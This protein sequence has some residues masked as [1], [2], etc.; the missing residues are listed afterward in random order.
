MRRREFITLLSGA[1]VAWPLAALAQQVGKLPTIGLLGVA[2]A[3]AWSRSMSAFLK[4]LQ[5]LGWAEGRTVAIEY[6]WAE[7]RRERF[8]EIAAEFVRLKVDVIVTAGGAVIA[9]KQETSTIPI[10][11]AVASDPVGSGLV[12]SLARPGGNVTGLSVQAGDLVG[13]RVRAI[14]RDGPRST[15]LGVMANVEYPAA[16]HELSEVKATADAMGLGIAV[17]EIRRADEIAAAIETIKGRAEALYVAIDALTDANRDRIA[18]LALAARLPM[19]PGFQEAIDAGG[20]VFY[21]PNV[22][23]LF[24]QAAGLVDRILRGIKPA[25]VPVEQ[26]TKIDLVINL[27]VARTLGLVVP[28]SLLARADEVIE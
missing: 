28:P 18:A 13:K 7:G 24:R 26:P 12:A 25:D 19:S 17:L 2:T 15:T 3:S 11:F 8:T 16:K 5:E 10:I 9:A 4:R 27:K 21:G 14:A 23:S 1:T 20:L 22:P 6:R